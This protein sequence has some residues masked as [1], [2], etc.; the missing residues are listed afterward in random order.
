MA[1]MSCES[2]VPPL[3]GKLVELGATFLANAQ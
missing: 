3:L 2:Q 1:S